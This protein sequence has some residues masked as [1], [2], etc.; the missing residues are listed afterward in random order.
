MVDLAPLQ[1]FFGSGPMLEKRLAI[2]LVAGC[3]RPPWKPLLSK[4]R[5]MSGDGPPDLGGSGNCQFDIEVNLSS[6]DV[7]VTRTLKVGEKLN[8]VVTRDERRDPTIELHTQDQRRASGI[9]YIGYGQLVKCIESGHEY[10]AEV[11]TLSP[12]GAG[13]ARLHNA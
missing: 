1:L 6:P 9:A 2:L 5:A 7:T 4:R 10:I 3:P 12:A 8:V 11:L 13:T